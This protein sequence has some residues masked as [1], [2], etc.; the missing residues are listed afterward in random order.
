MTPEE[1]YFFDLTGFLLI[2]N[3]VAPSDLERSA[4]AIDA[5]ETHVHANIDASPVTVGHYGQRYHVDPQHHYAAMR[6]GAGGPGIVVEDFV[7]F[8]PSLD[9]FL[10]HERVLSYVSEM[11]VGRFMITSLQVFLRYQGNFT[12]THMGG[13]I[14]ARN[15]YYYRG[16]DVLDTETG[17]RRFRHFEMNVVR[18]LFAI[19]D[20]TLADGPLCVVP[21]SHKANLHSPYSNDPTKEPL[22]TGIPMNAGDVLFFTENLR[23][24]GLP[25]TSGK[26]RKTIHITYQPRWTTSPSALHWNGRVPLSDPVRERLGNAAALF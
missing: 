19:H 2:R 18:V 6:F 5:L 17:E 11:I 26:T 15:K 22:M 8:S 7:N 3:A 4:K 23:H 12:P 16:T 10:A 1:A 25:I 13:P 21:G 9:I 14:D 24:G 20:I